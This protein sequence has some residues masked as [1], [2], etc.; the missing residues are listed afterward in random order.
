MSSALAQTLRR[1]EKEMAAKG[2]EYISTDH[3][4]LALTEPAPASP[5]S[6]RTA[7]RWKQAIGEVRPHKVTSPNPEDDR[8][9]RWRNSAAT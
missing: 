1:A 5:T 8:R 9:R 7:S 2:D 3:L 6:S 4:L